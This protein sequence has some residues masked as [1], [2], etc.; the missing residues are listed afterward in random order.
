RCSRRN[1]FTPSPDCSRPP[2][3][4]NRRRPAWWRHVLVADDGTHVSDKRPTERGPLHGCRADGLWRELPGNLV[5]VLPLLPEVGLQ[6]ASKG[7]D[8]TDLS[9]HILSINAR[10]FGDK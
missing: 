7:S 9:E 1:P 4:H 8:R 5:Y 3:H 6:A 2:A 10:I